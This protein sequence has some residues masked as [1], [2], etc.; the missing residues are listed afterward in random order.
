MKNL[1]K[2]MFGLLMLVGFFAPLSITA[3][4]TDYECVLF[5]GSQSGSDA[6]VLVCDGFTIVF[7]SIT[8]FGACQGAAGNCSG[9]YSNTP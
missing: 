4:G 3:Q 9:G 2:L 7:S 5:E 8:D 6:S 1:A